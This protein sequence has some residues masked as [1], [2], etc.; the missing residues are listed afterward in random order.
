MKWQE[1]EE[2]VREV[3]N[4]HGYET[5]FRVVFKD[6][7]GRGEIDV[8]AERFGLILAIDAKKYTEGWHRTSALKTQARKHVDRCK[9]FS[10]LKG[11]EVIP[12]I[13]SFIDDSIF[14]HSG[15]IV[16]PFEK[17]NDFLLNIHAYLIDF[18]ESEDR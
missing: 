17:L 15:C 5:K 2:F 12:I 7:E 16:V 18:N 11:S 6:S 9:R 1:F 4:K 14:Y 10:E 8:V 13:V 3:F